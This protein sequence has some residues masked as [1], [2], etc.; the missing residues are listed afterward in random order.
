MAIVWF[1]L[2]GLA[3]GFLASRL[4]K[5]GGFGLLGDLVLG[6]V[7]AFFGSFLFGVVG[8]AAYGLVGRLIMATVGAVVLL[9]LI[10]ILKRA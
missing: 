8:L 1:L 2:I 9:A 10:R 4:M 5:G 7:G 3:A 6:V